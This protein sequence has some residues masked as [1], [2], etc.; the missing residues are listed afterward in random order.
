M[1]L[2]CVTLF[3]STVGCQ[4]TSSFKNK[5][6][7]RT[8]MKSDTPVP[9]PTPQEAHVPKNA[10]TKGSFSAWTVP[11]NPAPYENYE[12]FVHVNYADAASSMDLVGSVL[13]TDGFVAQ[14]DESF[15]INSN[16]IS[17]RI[18]GGADLVR[19]TIEVRS[20]QLNEQQ[21]LEI[22]F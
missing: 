5:T 16:T 9:T 11:A 8:P 3:L 13:G 2:L 1:R 19:D 10:V 12:I 15:A 17:I 22:V 7:G 4:A 6:G 20:A 18:P 14:F 21:T